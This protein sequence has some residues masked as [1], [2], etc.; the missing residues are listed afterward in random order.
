M[1]DASRAVG[2]YE[3]PPTAICAG[4]HLILDGRIASVDEAAAVQH[5]VTHLAEGLGDGGAAGEMC[6]V[7]GG[8]C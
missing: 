2:C 7:R 4:L 5:A 6:G 8:D 1:A 3:Q